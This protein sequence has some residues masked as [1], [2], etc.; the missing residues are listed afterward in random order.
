MASRLGLVVLDTGSTSTFR[1]AG[2]RETIP[3]VS[4]ATESLA[5]HVRDWQVIED[6]T[7]SDH[8]YI[9]FR[10]RDGKPA[11]A[12]A[13][14]GPPCQKNGHREAVS[15]LERG[16]QTPTETEDRAAFS[17]RAKV[18][19]SMTMSLIHK[20]IT[21]VGLRRAVCSLKNK[22][23]P[24][25]DGFPAEVLKTVARSHPELLLRMYN[26]CLRVGVFYSRWKEARL[27]LIG[28]G[29]AP[30]DAPSSYRPLCMLDTAG[31]LLEKRL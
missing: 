13:Q 25:P 11:R 3:D 2:Y 28:K 15:G 27:V 20:V 26:S 6:F 23:A 16:Q 10:V 19:S 4:L 8:Q 1:R 30:A 29:K 21:L 31:K 7:A 17:A 22:N 12:A 5:A 9:T 18:V 14:S 24:G